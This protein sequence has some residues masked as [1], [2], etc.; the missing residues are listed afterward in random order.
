MVIGSTA[1][2][3]SATLVVAKMAESET[4]RAA[5]TPSIVTSQK[6]EQDRALDDPQEPKRRK[7][8]LRLLYVESLR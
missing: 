6:V 2:T 8:L 3:A 1:G 7:G 5:L 4:R